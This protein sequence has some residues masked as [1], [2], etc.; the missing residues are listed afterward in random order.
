MGARQI[1]KVVIPAAG[2][3]TRFLP[4]TKVVPKELLPVCGKPAIQFAVE[5]AVNSGLD[6][7]I[8]VLAKGKELIAEH[9]RPKISLEK[10][11]SERGKD[12]EW[13]LVRSVSELTDVRFV[14]QEAPLGLAD[15]IRCA[16][17]IVDDEP[18]AVILP[19]ALMDPSLACIRQLMNCYAR[20]SG[21]VLATR[22]VNPSE[23][24]RFGILELGEPENSALAGCV[25]RVGSL[26]EKP[27]PECARS[28][29]G[30]FGRYIL[31]P[32]IFE[33]IDE[34]PPDQSGELQ[35]TD[36]LRLYLQHA[37]I[38]AYCFEGTHY[39]I[40]DPFGFVQASIHYGLMDPKLGPKLREHLE[41]LD[42]NRLY[43]VS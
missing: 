22:E 42:S 36:S 16:R 41:E 9:F 28:R 20:F 38:Y 8:L 32:T 6:T 30:I 26:V 40:G 11:L 10:F 2:L 24:E 13:K 18:F 34:T 27:K 17:F 37:P 5:E 35:I 29:Y 14:W 3:G 7:V 19:D 23:V 43:P 15:A 1:R 33:Y 21:C 12:E 25:F 39:D 31:E 4:A